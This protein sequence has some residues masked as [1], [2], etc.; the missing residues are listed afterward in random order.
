MQLDN[1]NRYC[2]AVHLFSKRSQK[3]SK[4]SKNI[5]NTPG[6]FSF[7]SHSDII[8]DLLPNRCTTTM[9]L[10]VKYCITNLSLCVAIYPS[11]KKTTDRGW[12]P[13]SIFSSQGD[14]GGG[15]GGEYG[16]L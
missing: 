6:T 14:G 3:T 8:C 4:C 7:L 11:T 5:N 13:L 12:K 10:F 1:K 9:N 2:V 15:G 16:Y